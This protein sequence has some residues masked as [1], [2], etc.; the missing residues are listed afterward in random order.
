MT[1]R[2]LWDG[3]WDSPSD[4]AS[5]GVDR[6]SAARAASRNLGGS[7]FAAPRRVLRFFCT[8]GAGGVPAVVESWAGVV[9]AGPEG[10]AQAPEDDCT[11]LMGAVEVERGA[12]LVGSVGG[13]KC[14]CA[15]LNPCSPFLAGS[16]ACNAC[17]FRLFGGIKQGGHTG[18]SI[19]A[20]SNE[21]REWGVIF[22]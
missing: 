6:P 3:G 18:R 14:A 20:C 4:S 11:F 22:Q 16:S 1:R 15:V 10:T 9:V 8:T 7:W 21:R 12:A 2:R 13:Q 5:E 17:C 19:P